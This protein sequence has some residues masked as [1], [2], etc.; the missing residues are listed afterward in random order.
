[1]AASA[2]DGVNKKP[3]IAA[4]RTS[5]K[6]ISK[7]HFQTTRCAEGSVFPEK[8][9]RNCCDDLSNFGERGQLLTTSTQRRLS[10]SQTVP[11]AQD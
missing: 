5:A 6:R 4:A 11:W 10:E 8:A 7:L 3:G 1:P 9:S 2:R